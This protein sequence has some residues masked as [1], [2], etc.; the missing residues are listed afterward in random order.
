MA[1]KEA[2]KPAA[3]PKR[4][5]VEVQR[6]FDE[7]REEVEAEA[8]A[9]DAKLAETLRLR[10]A[11]VRSEVEGLGVEDV[12][13]RISTLGIDVARSLSDL[14]EKLAEEVKLLATVREAVGL[15]RQELQ[16]LHKID[17]TAT[18]LDQM[19]QEYGREKERLDTEIEQQRAE[20]KNE[21]ERVAAER[22]EQEEA[23]KKQRQRE[24]EEYE[25]KKNLDRKKER[26]KHEEDQRLLAKKNQERQEGLEKEWQMREA[27]LKESEE[28]VARLRKEAAEWPARLE[29]EAAGAAEK[30]RSEATAKLDQQ[31]LLLKSGA[32]TEKRIA[33]L[34]VKALEESLARSAQQVATLEK[35]LAEAKQQVQDIAVKAIEGASGARALSHI[36][37]IAMEQ[38]KNRPQG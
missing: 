25:Y 26:D 21:S 8:E 23:L 13:R 17:V 10:E 6:D 7:I 9:A 38:A 37:Q 20:W 12:V 11:Q 29:K 3:R 24:I 36:N 19:V 4:G 31:M 22:K 35:Q 5:R 15:E 32:E 1:T 30:A 14:S 28:D 34:K 18:A 33:E 27:A 16:R 2:K